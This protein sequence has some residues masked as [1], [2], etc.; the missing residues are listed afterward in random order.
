MSD[1]FNGVWLRPKENLTKNLILRISSNLKF[2][3]ILHSNFHWNLLDDW[4]RLRHMNVSAEEKNRF[5]NNSDQT[6]LVKLT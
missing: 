1:H 5:T 2:F 3:I 4:V 6:K